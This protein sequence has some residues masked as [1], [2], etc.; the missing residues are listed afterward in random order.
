MLQVWDGI[1]VITKS[2]VMLLLL[3]LETCLSQSHLLA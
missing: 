3:V 2:Q 1:S